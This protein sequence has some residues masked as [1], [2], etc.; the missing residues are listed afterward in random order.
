[1]AAF[2]FYLRF[3]LEEL[4]QVE[5]KPLYLL[6]RL[7]KKVYALF[8][9]E[10]SYWFLT[11]IVYW[12]LACIPLAA[13]YLLKPDKIFASI[14]VVALRLGF[15]L[16][17]LPWICCCCGGVGVSLAIAVWEDLVAEARGEKGVSLSLRE[18]IRRQIDFERWC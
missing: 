1:V 8:Y 4:R 10:Y 12:V 18:L 16:G 2:M 7:S 3:K 13:L 11:L 14:W 5:G 9:G 17:I 6:D 15:W